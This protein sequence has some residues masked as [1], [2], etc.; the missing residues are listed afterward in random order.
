M[1]HVLKELAV[2]E[3]R[4]GHQLVAVDE[5]R[6]RHTRVEQLLDHSIDR[7]FGQPQLQFLVDSIVFL[8]ATR[9]ILERCISAQ[10]CIAHQCAK[11]LPLL[12]G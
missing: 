5:W 4:I 9:P 6:S 2:Q 10:R 3:L 8:P 11:C 1:L 12:V 7:L